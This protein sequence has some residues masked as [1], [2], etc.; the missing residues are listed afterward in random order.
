MQFLTDLGIYPWTEEILLRRA[1]AFPRLIEAQLKAPPGSFQFLLD[2]LP[3][4]K[5]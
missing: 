2:D 4:N 5:G 1:L 3:G